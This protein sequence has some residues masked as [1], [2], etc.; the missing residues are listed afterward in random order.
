M[1]DDERA[2]RT[3]VE[4]WMAASGSGDLTPCSTE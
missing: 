1:T 3:V 2:I 4:T